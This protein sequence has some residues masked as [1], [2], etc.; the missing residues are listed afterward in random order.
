MKP[1]ALAKWIRN[2]D[3]MGINT[4][5]EF[6]QDFT[7][8]EAPKIKLSCDGNFVLYLNDS[9]VGCGQYQGYEDLQF[10]EEYDLSPFL[11][12]GVNHLRILAHH[13]GKD[14]ST[15]RASPAGLIF[16]VTDGGQVLCASS[17]ETLSRPDTRYRF[18]EEVGKVTGQLGF[19]FAF[20]Q[21]AAPAPWQA[22]V[23]S[24]RS[25]ELRRRPIKQLKILPPAPTLLHSYGTFRDTEEASP[26]LQMQN[27]Y[28]KTTSDPRPVYFPYFPGIPLTAPD[29]DGTFV[30]VDLGEEST[31]FFSMEIELSAPAKILVG[32]GEHLSD[33]RV[34]TAIDGR[35]FAFSL[36]LPAGRQTVEFPL[37]RLG[38]RYLQ[39]HIYAP[40]C[41]LYY[42]GIR[43]TLYPI[44]K[45]APAPIQD[46]LHQ[47]I[48]ETCIHTLHL[49]MHEHY[50]D[51][52][53]R[54]QALYA[55]D[56][57]NQ[58]LIGYHVFRETR[59]AKASLELIAHSLRADG[60][61][62][63]CSP[64]R[65]SVNIPAFSAIFLVQLQEYLQYS[66][67]RAFVKRMLPTARRVADNFLHR[68]E[69][70]GLIRAIP[71]YWNFYEWQGSLSG[72]QPDQNSPRR[73]YDAPLCAF[74][75]M[76]LAA[77]AKICDELGEDGS[78]YRS[79]KDRMAKAVQKFWAPEQG[80]YATY[81]AE[82]KIHHFCEL[83]NALFFCADLVPQK[84]KEKVLKKLRHGPLIPI[85]LSHSIFKYQAL[86]S[87][88]NNIDFVLADIAERFGAMLFSG[89]TT[90]WETDLGEQD[91]SN[92][93]S[94][95]HGWSAVPAY[96]YFLIK[97]IE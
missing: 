40:D 20:D 75:A 1:F 6:S 36:T 58:M 81:L 70:N 33:L 24:S 45:P 82:E 43:P 59:F 53:W 77:L 61:L 62:E 56:S 8:L 48:Y 97:E 96:V 17:S 25:L 50:E 4:Y 68:I 63:L 13:P 84:R 72:N 3:C 5:A 93:G 32:W 30:L 46:A 90:F 38:L 15:H 95:C 14:F 57:R 39:L 80:C 67:D 49:C 85:T 44:G 21:T 64:A 41:T 69:R 35:N 55:M 7:P 83:T 2:Q 87:D 34:R 28:L 10:F 19:T 52:P 73:S 89:A 27:A 26:A 88:P 31:G 78:C 65:V 22:S 79:C 11:I 94:L 47:K 71:G 16:E 86:L 37:L 12:G 29:G 42:A 60:F 91:F 18:G 92:A 9:F 76:G 74:V 66:N 23:L 51:C 54:E